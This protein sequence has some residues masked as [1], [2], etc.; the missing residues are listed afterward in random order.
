M[1]LNLKRRIIHI[2]P[3]D[4]PSL[5][6]STSVSFPLVWRSFLSLS[7]FFVASSHQVIS[8]GKNS[9]ELSSCHGNPRER[10][11]GLNS[12]G[13]KNINLCIEPTTNKRWYACVPKYPHQ[14]ESDI[15]HTSRIVYE[16]AS[17]TCVKKPSWWG[18]IFEARARLEFKARTLPPVSAQCAKHKRSSRALL[19]QNQHVFLIMLHCIMRQA[20]SLHDNNKIIND[21]YKELHFVLKTVKLL[22]QTEVR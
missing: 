7:F 22:W 13:R 4:N 6:T 11:S 18:F 17:C 20:L 8:T 21:N 10:S 16:M 2:C 3:P 9:R 19:H 15:L 5:H 1:K 12:R 14:W